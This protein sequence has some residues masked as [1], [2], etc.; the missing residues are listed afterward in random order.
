KK[1]DQQDLD[2]EEDVPG[3]MEPVEVGDRATESA[4]TE[5]TEDESEELDEAPSETEAPRT[6]RVARADRPE[7]YLVLHV[8][9]RD[10][11][12]RGQNLL[13]TLVDQDMRYGEMDIFHRVDDESGEALFSLANAVE[14]GTFDLSTM[15]QMTTPGVTLFMK[16][17]D[18]DD[19]VMVYNDMLQVA[20]SLA[21]ELEGE[22]RDESRSVLTPQT[23]EHCRQD[24]KDYQLKYA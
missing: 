8:L 23:I 24:I 15:D 4:D 6:P 21:E 19:P 10:A 14:P 18:L 5:E 3:L 22:V 12:F 11:Q 1:S 9:S 16:V 17:H 2:V 20:D 7:K 13:E